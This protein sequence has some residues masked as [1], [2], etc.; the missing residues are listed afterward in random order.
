MVINGGQDGLSA[1][2]PEL[3]F[4][5]EGLQRGGRAESTGQVRPAPSITARIRYRN[6]IDGLRAIAVASVIL[7][8]FDSSL[9]PGGY[10][11]VDMFFVI[12][13]Y[14]ISLSLYS[15]E[16]RSLKEL[17]LGF[18]ARRF[19]RLLPALA[20]CVAATSVLISLINPDPSLSLKTGFAA[21]F[22]LSNFF[23]LRISNDY[24]GDASQ[25]NA[26]THTWS[27]GVEEQFYLVFPLI[28]WAVLKRPGPSGFR[29]F[30]I[31]V[32]AIA[33]LSLVLLAYV[34]TLQAMAAFY[35]MPLRFWEMAAGCLV[36][37]IHCRRGRPER[38]DRQWLES[39]VV[40]LIVVALF[41]APRFALPANVLVVA[42]TAAGLAILSPDSFACR[43]L[44]SRPA[45][46]LGILS[47]SLYLW[48]WPILVL[49]RFT[50]GVH[51]WSVPILAELIFIVAYGSYHWVEK[52]LRTR[53]WG[54]TDGVTVS[55]GAAAACGVAGLVAVMAVPLNGRF[56]TGRPA[57]LKVRNVASLSY[58][59]QVPRTPYAWAG[60]DCILATDTDIGRTIPLAACTL[61]RMD[62]AQRRVMVFG[63]SFSAAFVHGFDAL[64]RDDHYA[65][66]ITSSWG[67]SPIAGM[68]NDSPWSRENTYYWGKIVPQM[69]ARLRPGDWVFLLSDV[70]ELAPENPGPNDA[71]N[72]ARYRDSLLRLSA[73]LAQA[74]VRLAVLDANPFIREAYCKPDTAIPQWFA[75]AGGPCKYLTRT[76]TIARR[77]P[78]DTML[79]QLQ[80]QHRL[81]LIDLLDLFCPG[82][83]CTFIGNDHRVLYR[84]EFSHASVEAASDAAPIFRQVFTSAPAA[85]QNSD[86][87]GALRVLAHSSSTNTT[88]TIPV[89][90]VQRNTGA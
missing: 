79:R 77:H 29:T 69:M 60:A 54:R 28:L 87:D 88:A 76:G 14:V 21:L 25:L 45:H 22:G 58:P 52:P 46:D 20:L 6:E 4:R 73:Q 85:P 61:G 48:H 90:A 56:Y 78:L 83:V 16:C 41:C 27:L 2:S 33:A 12:S 23:L 44:T 36:A 3:F 19:K 72:L 11:G 47:Y 37:I 26:F 71:R 80:Q 1:G 74:H 31:V 62:Q 24:F 15:R 34:G 57:G 43:V 5:D 42:L 68:P 51:W 86:P 10:L 40:A 38:G 65:V 67:A 35:L 63:N 9:V 39:L 55:W 30:F 8:H 50:V 59:Y 82:P 89:A 66:T 32:A 49:S 64:V 75:P 18:Y 70:A 84:D 13:G 17:L 81:V 7:N 53:P